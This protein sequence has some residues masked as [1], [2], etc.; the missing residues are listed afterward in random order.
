MVTSFE[1]KGDVRMSSKTPGFR[2]VLILSWLVAAED[3]QPTTVRA[4]NRSAASLTPEAV[5]EAIAAAQDG[6]IVVLP[7]GT[8]VWKKGWNTG[9]W[10]KM[11]AITIQGA[12]IDKT[13]VRDET[14]RAAG[15]EPFVINGVEGK[16]F[17]ITGMTFD[18][19][20]L[21]DA[22]VWAGAI[23]IDG[24]CKNFRVD[25]CKFLNMDRMMTINGDTYGLIDHCDFHAFKKNRLAQTIMYQGPGAVNY[26]KPLSLGTPRPSTSRTTRPILARRS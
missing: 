2:L 6:D 22:G 9:H 7:A 19:T 1:H 25:H 5:W 20:G 23:V 26:R 8:A 3:F 17:R 14:S 15:D 16:P 24:N 21:A 10:A 12:G 11:K 18:G 4:E 13:I